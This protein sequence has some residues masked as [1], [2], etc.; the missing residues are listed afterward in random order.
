MTIKGLNQFIKDR[1]SH[2][3]ISIPLTAF[4]GKR[5]AIDTHLW[6][7]SRMSACRTE[8]FSKVNLLEPLEVHRTAILK[9]WFHMI[10]DFVIVFLNA[11]VTPIFVF[12][13]RPPHEKLT[14]K[15]KRNDEKEATAREIDMLMEKLKH[16]QQTMNSAVMPGLTTRLRSLLSRPVGL[17]AED[18]DQIKFL[19]YSIGIPCCQCKDGDTGEAERLCS[20]LCIEGHAAATFSCD[21]DVLAHGC[22]LQIRE[23]G[24]YTSIE[25]VRVRMCECTRLDTILQTLN[26]T[27]PQFVDLC[28]AAGCDYNPNIPNLAIA[29]LY[30][31]MPGGMIENITRVFNKDIT[32]LN[33]HRS[34]S[35]FAHLPTSEIMVNFCGLGGSGGGG[36]GGG[37][38]GGGGSGGG[39]SGGGGSGGGGS[40]GGGSGGGGSGGGGSDVD[41]ISDPL[42]FDVQPNRL[43]TARDYLESIGCGGRLFELASLY[44]RL[45]PCVGGLLTDLN[46]IM[47][48]SITAAEPTIVVSTQPVPHPVYQPAQ[49]SLQSTYPYQNYQQPSP[50]QPINSPQY[51]QYQTYQT[52]QQSYTLPQ[53]SY[54]LSTTPAYTPPSTSPSSTSLPQQPIPSFAL[55]LPK[56][57]VPSFNLPQQTYPQHSL[58]TQ[59]SVFILP[60]PQN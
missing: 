39:G 41:I 11:G 46:L 1:V 22:P 52:Y 33:H 12:D 21:G 9:S 44:K 4:D 49:Q 60:L 2:A 43:G 40:G 57:P 25:G 36:S 32:I 47:P 19:L 28:I 35:L 50:F 15:K 10:I 16:A 7:Y 24:G 55:P 23:F 17:P 56:Q 20:A 54:T 59:K 29:G 8:V 34:R 6:M 38:S 37:G 5:V 42:K 51:Q 58:P 45:K 26:L 3:K 48:N 53:P 30:K 31:K 14:V 18:V 13:G 27:F